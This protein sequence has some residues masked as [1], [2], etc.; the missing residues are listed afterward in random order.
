[1]ITL[2]SFIIVIGIL[3]FVHELGHFLVAKK[4]G[5]T[6][7]KFSLGFGPKLIGF[8]RG[9]TQ[10]MI[11]AIPLGGYVK[12][13]GENPDE[14]LT[15]ERGEFA[16]RSVGVRAAI[17]AAGPF[18][19]C[20]LCFLIMPLVYLI[21]IQVPAYLEEKPVVQWIGT[22]SPAEQAGM[23]K[24]DTI[25][26]VNDEAVDNWKMFNALTQINP[27]TAVRIRF[28]RDGRSI[29]TTIQPPAPEGAGAGLGI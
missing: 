20:A 5:V 18:M 2:L 23:Q 4:T 25:L 21:G 1:M 3:I 27:G 16:S 14:A 10:Y 26:A 13:K 28:L 8:E 15:N 17:V 22:K 9:G 24:G 29:V 7:E 19:N 11:C 6:V 12:L